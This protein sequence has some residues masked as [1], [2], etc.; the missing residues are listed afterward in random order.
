M[1]N[2]QARR[3]QMEAVAQMVPQDGFSFQGDGHSLSVLAL[4]LLDESEVLGTDE[5]RTNYI[6]NNLLVL[7]EAFDWNCTD[8][9]KKMLA[10]FARLA[11]LYPQLLRR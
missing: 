3:S 7:A 2:Y 10:A 4:L 8:N 6:A 1:N 11:V 5:A 9:Q